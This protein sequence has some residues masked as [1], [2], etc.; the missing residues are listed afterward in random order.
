MFHY[1]QPTKIHFGAGQL[2]ELGHVC[3]GYGKTCFLVTTPDAPLQPLYERVKKLLDAEG[4]SVIHFDKVEPN[5][6]VEIVE[7]GFAM[8]KE[9][10]AD[11]VLAVGGGSSIDRKSVV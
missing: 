7:Q 10:P 6:S 9:Q 11:F 1:Y 3:R 5:P 2:N 4:I 8:L